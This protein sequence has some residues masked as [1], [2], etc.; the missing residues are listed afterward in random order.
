MNNYLLRRLLV[1]VP[2][3]IGITMLIFLVM[4]ILPGD[5]VSVV[6]GQEAFVSL[7][8]ADQ[9]RFRSD[10][11]LNKPLYAQYLDWMAA[12]AKGDLGRS[13]WRND[14]VADLL[15]RRGPITVQIALMA[16]VFSWLVGIPVGILSAVRRGSMQDH[17]ARLLATLFLAIPSFW[18]GVAVVLVGVLYFS[19]RPPIEI[20]YLWTDPLKNL[21]MTIGPAI[22]LGA[23]AGAY[24]ARITRSS[25]LELMYADFVRTARAKGV[26]ERQVIW[27]HVFI[28]AVLPV[29]TLSGLILAGLLGGSVAVET[30]FGVPG[31]GTALVRALADRDYMV[32][33]NLVLVYAV[34][35]ATVNLAVDLAYGWFD[36]RIRY[37]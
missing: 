25:I 27:R 26:G 28:N 5:P 23:G 33:Q 16:I 29:L 9:E 24:V 32:V 13:F 15:A 12:V 30:A 31:L 19:W 2:T 34:I 35:F 4:R 18:L 37:D 8:A 22:A 6:F 17:V 21:Q 10:L 36:P 3:I 20:A 7:S 14:T 11:G 1:T